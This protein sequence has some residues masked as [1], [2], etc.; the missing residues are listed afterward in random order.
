MRLGFTQTLS[1]VLLHA[2]EQARQLGQ[3]FVGTEHLLLGILAGKSGD[4]FRA[5]QAETNPEQLLPNLTRALPKAAEQS[6]VTGRLTLSPKA[7][8]AINTAISQAQ[9]A[10]QPSVSTRFVLLALLADGESA[11]GQILADGGADLEELRGMLSRGDGP[12]EE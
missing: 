1:A 11:V 7:Q 8:R 4:A 12:G 6:L 10:G 2:D 5:L 3:E 9:A